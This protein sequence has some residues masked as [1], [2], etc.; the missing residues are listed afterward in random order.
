MQIWIVEYWNRRWR[1][2]I[3]CRLHKTDAITELEKWQA[4]DPETKFRLRKYIP[5]ITT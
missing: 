2:T 4:R 1:P 3:G 5:K